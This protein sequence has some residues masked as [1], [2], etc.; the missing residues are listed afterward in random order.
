MNIVYRFANID[1]KIR[2]EILDIDEK[3]DHMK[4]SI[5]NISYKGNVGVKRKKIT[6]LI[7]IIFGILIQ[8]KEKEKSK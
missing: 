7:I 1:D 3:H 8:V 4:L 2:V 5:K 6:G